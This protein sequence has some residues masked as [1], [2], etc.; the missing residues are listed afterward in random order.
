MYRAGRQR[1]PRATGPASPRRLIVARWLGGWPAPRIAEQL[2]I[3]R[4]TVHKWINRYRAQ[5]W[6]G[7]AGRSS[8]PHHSPTRTPGEVEDRVLA[9]RATAR[10]GPV[11][12]ARELGM[13]A[14]TVGRILRRHQVM[15]LRA[16]D[17]I[18]GAP[19]RR[20]HPGRRYEHPRPGDLVHVDVKKLGRVP[21]GGA[22]RLHGRSEQVR[23]RKVHG[24]ALGYYFLHVAVDD[25]SRLAYVEAL[26]DERDL[27]SAG[28]LRRATAWSAGH[29]VTGQRVLT[30]NA[31]V[32][33]AGPT[34][35]SSSGS[36]GVS[37]ARTARGRTRRR[38]GSTGPCKT[39]SP[40][41]EHGCPTPNASPH[42]TAGSR[43][44]T[45][46]EPTP[47]SAAT[48]PSPGSPPEPVDNLMGHHT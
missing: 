37:P 17:P 19:V 33:R 22:W 3:S 44:T 4:A 10:R 5:G 27:T 11:F 7:L 12:L 46:D 6:D 25:H 42:S 43:T 48:H 20:Q 13:V 38:S 39:S 41:P 23:G 34:R 45:L 26:P 32:Y 8:R 40:T 35:V 9:L 24:R 30:D 2:G 31:R 36:G 1:R 16:L 14:S 18:T 21:D 29:G 28:F 47:P 15:P